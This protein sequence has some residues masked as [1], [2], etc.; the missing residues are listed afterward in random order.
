MTSSI[1]WYDFE[2]TGIN[3]RSDRPLQ[4]AG[5]RT[6]LGLN[7]IEEPINYYCQLSDDI[8]PHPQACLVTGITPDIL[9]K[10]GLTE[11][12]FFEKLHQQLARP[13]TCTAGYNSIRFDDEVCRYGFYRNFFDPYGREWQGGNSRWDIID[14]LRTCY[15]LRPEGVVWPRDDESNVTL[16]LELLT[17]L[18]NIVHENAHDALSDVR[19]TIA[20]AKLV[21]EKQ[22]K[23]YDYLFK[24]RLKREVQSNITLLKPLVHISGRFSAAQHYLSVVLPLAWHPENRN[25]VIVCNLQQDIKPLFEL[26]AEQIT[27]YLYTKR[28]DLPADISPI[29]LKLIHINR[30]PVI[31]PLKVLREQ[32]INRIA[33]NLEVCYGNAALL[34]NNQQNWQQKLPI[35]YKKNNE[36]LFENTVDDP[37]QQLYAG[38]LSE[39][40]R[41]LCDQIR[42][43]NPQQLAIAQQFEDGRLDELFFRYRARNYPESLSQE[44]KEQWQVFCSQRL[45]DASLGAPITIEQF[46]EAYQQALPT[47]DSQQYMLLQRWLDYINNQQAKYQAAEKLL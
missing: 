41:R 47:C 32:D 2:T 37:E 40:D 5:I 10:Q 12:V 13:Q 43:L 38:F 3:P 24:L 30:C 39:R 22:P 31:A 9:I 44:Q 33:I 25:A 7:E 6:D 29:P 26:T 28:E 16:R 36:Q 15:A 34:V 17:A 1:F 23:L 20:L 21:K 35:I 8:L 14:L 42:T 45:K 19:A 4:V 27:E 18:N 11:A 46:Y